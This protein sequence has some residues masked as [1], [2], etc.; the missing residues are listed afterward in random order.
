MNKISYA[1]LACSMLQAC[2]TASREK[3]AIAV[4]QNEVRNTCHPT[5]ELY[6]QRNQCCRM[7]LAEKNCLLESSKNGC[8]VWQTKRGLH[9]Q[10]K[11][12][13]NG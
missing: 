12:R 10:S 5:Y 1:L 4:R 3:G 2:G 6:A 8:L 13:R 7:E 11:E 9:C